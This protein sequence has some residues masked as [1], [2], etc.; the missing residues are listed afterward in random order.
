M[1]LPLD[2]RRNISPTACA[3]PVSEEV[4]SKVFIG[5]LKV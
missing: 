3:M 2:L 5:Y 1:I 4:A